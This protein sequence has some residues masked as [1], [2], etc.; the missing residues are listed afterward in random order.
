MKR[1]NFF[2]P[3]ELVEALRLVAAHRDVTMSELIRTALQKFLDEME[4]LPDE[5]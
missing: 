5:R 1:H 2:L 4:P 3:V